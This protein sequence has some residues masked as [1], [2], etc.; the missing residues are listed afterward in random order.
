MKRL[1]VILISVFMANSA[2]AFSTIRDTEIETTVR[3]LATPIFKAA[4][5]VPENITIILVNDPQINAFVAGGQ[6]MFINTGL[7]MIFPKP[8]VL[9]GVMAHET[10]HIAGGH[11]ARNSDKMKD[12]TIGSLVSYGLGAITAV[13]GAPQAG[14]AVMQGGSQIAQREALQYSRQ[15]ENSADEA[16]LKFLDRTGNTASGLLEL[17]EYLN[18]LEHNLYGEI[19]PY[20][21]TH[22]L[23]SERIEH[24]RNHV[25][26]TP[27]IKTGGT[28][29]PQIREEY[30][31]CYVKLHAFFDPVDATLKKYPPSDQSLLAHYARA[32]A[33][34]KIPDLPKSFAELD[35][36]LKTYPKDPYFNELKG[37]ILFE[38]GHITDAIPYYQ[39]AVAAMPGD[40]LLNLGLGTTEVA[41]ADDT[42]LPQ[43]GP[44]LKDAIDHLNY[45]QLKESANLEILQQIEIAYGR[46]GQI[47]MAYLSHAESALLEKK[48]D[49]ARN[50]AHLAEMNLP[51]GSPASIRAADILKNVKP[52]GKK[53]KGGSGERIP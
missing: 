41:A 14:I 29:T 34:Q 36:L 50:F 53:D 33:Y 37:Q 30:A 9:Q 44:W 51:A 47:G 13:M 48:N 32:I 6:N 43:S 5:L 10:G 18:N 17:M 42:D 2:Y 38:N 20:L 23:S 46:S 24:V 39:H 4:G 12:L 22:P 26:S 15:N 40:A 3:A 8:E 35:V 31:R 19:N 11:L 25:N 45:A 49:E 52:N 27:Y 1:L 7:I 21:Q 16:A 28:I